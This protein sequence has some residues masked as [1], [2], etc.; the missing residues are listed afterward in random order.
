MSGPQISPMELGRIAPQFLGQ[1]RKELRLTDQE[2]NAVRQADPQMWAYWGVSALAG[3]ERIAYLPKDEA[4]NHFTD[5]SL[6]FFASETEINDM[7]VLDF[8]GG[9]LARKADEMYASG[10][11][12]VQQRFERFSEAL[13]QA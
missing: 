8:R 12:A 4:G 10:N 7:E 5:R 3:D 9:E 2:F 13:L 6:P 11:S 1:A